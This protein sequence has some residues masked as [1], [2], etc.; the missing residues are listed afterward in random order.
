[1]TI[2][3]A[4]QQPAQGRPRPRV[5]RGGRGVSP[6]LFAATDTNKDG[7]VTRGE[8]KTTLDTW[9]TQWDAAGSGSVTQDQVTA[10]L[11]RRFNPP[12]V[13]AGGVHRAE[14]DAESQ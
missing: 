12:V 1:M 11:M 8:F 2:G 3:S 7:T 9:F 6:A 4:A 13:V 14:S 10:G 5:A